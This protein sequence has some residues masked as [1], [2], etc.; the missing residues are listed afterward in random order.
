MHP[1]IESLVKS[2]EKQ[3]P[4]SGL[5]ELAIFISAPFSDAQGERAEGSF[6]RIDV[7]H[8]SPQIVAATETRAQYIRWLKHTK[9]LYAE[10]GK[11]AD[12][13]GLLLAGQKL[14]PD[15]AKGKPNESGHAAIDN[16]DIPRLVPS[17]TNIFHRIAPRVLPAS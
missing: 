17:W 4:T 16:N 6:V 9:H 8:E 15:M 14:L 2:A 3:W 1:E 10:I 11:N 5:H 7:A 12:H 13:L